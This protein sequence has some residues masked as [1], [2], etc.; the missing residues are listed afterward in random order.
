M[1]GVL[2][3]VAAGVVGAMAWDGAKKLPLDKAIR[4]AAVTTTATGLRGRRAA[5]SGAER[6]RLVAG[7]IVA[8]AR[9]RVGETAPVPGSPA[10]D[11]EH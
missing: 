9:E 6:L 10:V 7:D 5:E 8:E 11:H 1:W 2:G 4:E 3:K